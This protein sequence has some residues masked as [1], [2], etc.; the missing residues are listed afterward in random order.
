DYTFTQAGGCYADV[1]G[2]LTVDCNGIS[3]QS[4]NIFMSII[5]DGAEITSA[6][7][8]VSTSNHPMI[9]SWVDGHVNLTDG[10]NTYDYD[11]TEFDNIISGVAFGTYDYTFTQA[12]G[13]YADVTGTLTVDCNGISPQSGN[14]F[15]SIIDDGAPIEIDN[16]V[17][18]SDNVLTADAA[19][20]SYQWID[21]DNANAPIQGE[22]GQSYTATVNGNYAVI[23][24]DANC[25]ETSDCISVMTIGVHEA[26]LSDLSFYPNPVQN[27][28]NVDLSGLEENVSFDVVS[29][30]GKVVYSQSYSNEKVRIDL[31]ELGAG[32]YI[33][34]VRTDK[35]SLTKPIIKQ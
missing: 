7:V 35:E 14:I 25:S 19:G 27:I 2:T 6:P 16:A 31:S 34:N 15:M 9:G 13:C 17:T 28:L 32:M 3:P 8:F 12:G 11:V 21:C 29:L 5:D 22:T 24:T 18:Q 26:V 20:L 23:I 1:T 4:G 10:G 30:S 33:L